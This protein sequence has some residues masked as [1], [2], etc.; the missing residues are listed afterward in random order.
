MQE[1]ESILP[2]AEELYKHGCYN[3]AANMFIKAIEI[4][5]KYSAPPF[6]ELVKV[7][8]RLRSCMV[9]DG[10]KES[11]YKYPHELM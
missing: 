1:L 8:Q 2:D 6:P 10:N 7:Q 5:Y 9:H 3:N 11:D 4:Y